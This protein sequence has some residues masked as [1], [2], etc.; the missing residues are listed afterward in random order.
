MTPNNLRFL[1]LDAERSNEHSRPEVGRAQA[2]EL[3]KRQGG[4]S[5][6]VDAMP[7]SAWA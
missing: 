7:S 2:V 5:V 1:P 6:V 3:A 4:V